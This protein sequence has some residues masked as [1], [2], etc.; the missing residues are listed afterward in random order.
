[1]G[2]KEEKNLSARGQIKTLEHGQNFGTRWRVALGGFEDER[3]A[4]K[5]ER[6]SG[7]R[8]LTLPADVGLTR[9]EGQNMCNPD[10]GET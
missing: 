5:K 1:M 6:E 7:R 4:K 9:R 8:R 3:L 2:R 10:S